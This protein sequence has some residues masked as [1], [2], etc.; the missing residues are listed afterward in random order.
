[1]VAATI[2][3]LFPLYNFSGDRLTVA[4]PNAADDD[5]IIGW[6]LRQFSNFPIKH[7]LLL[8]QYRSPDEENAELRKLVLGIAGELS[9]KVIDPITVL[10]NYKEGDLWFMYGHHNTRLGNEVV[11]SYLFEHGFR[12]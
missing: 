10:R 1:M 4:H 9:L 2:D 8:L 6:T 11:C 5:E 3:R 7:K 12:R